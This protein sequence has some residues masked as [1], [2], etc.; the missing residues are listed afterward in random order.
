MTVPGTRP[1]LQA[2][3][4]R[5]RNPPTSGVRSG[6]VLA[7]ASGASIVLNY[8]FLLASGRVLG[9]DAYGSLAALL[10]LLA[11][12]LI[13]ATAIQLAVS[14]EVSRQIASGDTLYAH[15]FVQRALR[16]SAVATVPLLV[17]AFALAPLLSH[18]L[19]IDSTGMVALAETTFAMA[20]VTPVAMG[21]IQGTQ[22]F[23][24]LA[25]LY[26]VPFGLRL[27]V[28]AVAAAAGYRL[29]AAVSATVVSSVAGAALALYLSRDFLGSVPVPSP[30]LRPFLRYLG[31]VAIGLVGI[32]LLTHV[33]VLVVKARF[34]ADDAGA[35]AGASAFARVGFF[36]PA[37]ILAVLFPRTAARQARGEQTEDILGRSLI[38]TIVFCGGLALFYAAAGVGLIVAT[39]GPGFAEGGRVLAPFALAIGLFSISNVLVG[40]HLSRGDTRYA[41][42]VAAGVPVQV[43]LLALVPTSL[44]GVVWTNAAVGAALIVGHEVLVGSSRSALRAGLRYVKAGLLPLRAALPETGLVLLS[45]TAFVC[46]LFWPVVAHL[47]STVLGTP[48]S[49][50]T[51]GIAFFWDLQHEGGYHLLGLTHHTLLA[52]PFG[53][54]TT[55]A[56]NVQLFLPYYPTYLA[57]HV[58]GEI[59]ALNLTTLAGYILPGAAMYLLVRYLGCSRLVSA[60]AVLVY[61]VFPWHLAR[62]EH[63]SLLHIEVLALLI[64]ALVAAARKPSWQRVALVGVANLA[65]WLTSGY[66]GAMA[67]VTSVAFALGAALVSDRARRLPLLLGTSAVAIA[68]AAVIGIAAVASGT[69]TGAGLGREAVDLSA[70]G[71]RPV[72]LVVPPEK[73]WFLGSHLD[74]FWHAHSHG[75]NATELSNYLGL[76][77]IALALGW[78]V[79]AFRRR[80]SIS[81]T[82]RVA[83]AGLVAVFV[84]GLLF[85]L[86]SPVS[87]FGHDVWMPSRLLWEAL[88]AFRVIS[89]WDP[90]LMTALLPLAALGLQT[91]SR[92]IAR[93]RQALAFSVVGAAMVLSFVELSVHPA[94]PRFRT[95]PTPPE[96]SA[97]DRTPP[98]IVA[99]YPLGQSDIYRFWQRKHRRPLLNGAEPGTEADYARLVLLDPTQPGTA[100]ALSFLGVTAVSVHPGAHADVEIQ[101]RDPAGSHGYRLVARYPHERSIWYPDGASV[102]KVVAPPAPALVTLPGGFASPQRDSRGVVVY[103][104]VSTAGVGVLEF[105]ARTPAVVRLVFDATAPKGKAAS[106]RVADSKSEQKFALAGRTAVSV[107]VAIPRGRS[108][109]LLKTDPP[110]PTPA[111]ALLITTPRAERASGTPALHAGLVSSNPGL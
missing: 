106:L 83:T 67:A 38:A 60:W 15:A 23:N 71:L 4:D 19:N 104:L 55:N 17:V 50:S 39:F 110:P 90:L 74:S 14:R 64:V 94:E 93:N 102:W 61:I 88:P 87:V 11:V 69:N 105:T 95:V 18:L 3:R 57:A 108:Q 5:V 35:Y 40:Y 77:T 68:P 32:A 78:L 33:D 51:G 84:A 81:E 2:R 101:P 98:G 16:V 76:L 80:A 27:A 43:L 10:G 111:D 7:V 100:S 25:S 34:S 91:A 26:V 72:E 65:C 8:V 53:I 30:D 79:V 42:I 41:W 86:P 96:Y 52:A 66:F 103:P 99:E 13:P 70:F 44:H 92:A 82:Q 21:A 48:G 47:G 62:L 6:A 36:L 85:A 75:S 56:V 29:G 73:S 20:L 22:R 59:A 63:A 89:R 49:D 97:I 109:L 37:T 9:S 58:V 107:L 46:V 28:F 24:A 45:T 1:A 31:P 12:V 54:D